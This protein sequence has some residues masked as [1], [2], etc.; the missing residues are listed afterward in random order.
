MIATW[1]SPRK[2]RGRDRM[3]NRKPPAGKIREVRCVQALEVGVDLGV[4]AVISM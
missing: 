1:R 4:E 3:S 2:F